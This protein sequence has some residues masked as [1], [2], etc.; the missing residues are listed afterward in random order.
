M[1]EDSIQQFGSFEIIFRLFCSIL[2][3]PFYNLSVQYLTGSSKQTT[4]ARRCINRNFLNIFWGIFSLIFTGVLQANEEKCPHIYIYICVCIRYLPLDLRGSVFGVDLGE[5][6][7]GRHGG[8]R[9][10]RV[11]IVDHD[12]PESLGRVQRLV[13]GSRERG[14]GHRNQ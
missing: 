12:V 1:Y 4:N 5:G 10:L 9:A 14:R 13:P 3:F 7:E 6:A 2:E 11:R 8:T